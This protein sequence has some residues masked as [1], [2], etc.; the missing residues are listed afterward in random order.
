MKYNTVDNNCF[1]F[2]SE[3]ALIQT[4]PSLIA[5]ACICAAMRGLRMPSTNTAINDI[6]NLLHINPETLEDLRRFVDQTVEK[7]IPKPTEKSTTPNSNACTDS[8]FES[9]KYG[10]PETPTEVEDVYF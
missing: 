8:G 5:S 1:I 2:V 10:Q 9:P 6:S 4:R 7:G 3:P